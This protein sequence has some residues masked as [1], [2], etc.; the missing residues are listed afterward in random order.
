MLF[1]DS[2]LHRRGN[3]RGGFVIGLEGE[4][5]PPGVFDNKAAKRFVD[6]NEGYF[7]FRYVT[8]EDVATNLSDLGSK[9]KYHPRREGYSPAEVALSIR[10]NAPSM[11]I[12]DSLNEPFW[13]PVDYWNICRDFPG[14][15]FL[16]AHA[17]GYSIRDFVKIC[18]IQRNVY[19]DFSLTHSVFGGVADNPLPG[20]DEL[21]RY[22]LNS[23]FADR[24]LMGSDFPYS[25]Q[26]RV[27]EYYSSR[28]FLPKVNAN[29]Q[30][31]TSELLEPR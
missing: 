6:L 10:R 28:G 16:L 22:S 29:F 30:K 11:V 17:G 12:L 31:L 18:H 8:H 26:D 2:H 13:S 9:L 23:M 14:V 4:D 20:V 15:K 24:V 3:E 21:I 1:F 19:I 25:C 27:A 7:F 5:L